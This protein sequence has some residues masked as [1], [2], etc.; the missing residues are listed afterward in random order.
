MYFLVHG[1]ISFIL[2]NSEILCTVYL[3]VMFILLKFLRSDSVV[4]NCRAVTLNVQLIIF[5]YLSYLFY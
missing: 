4:T 1:D 3:S 2:K 5:T